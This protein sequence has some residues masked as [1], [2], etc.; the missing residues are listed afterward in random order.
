MVEVVSTFETLVN[1][2]HTTLRNYTEDCHLDTRRENVK[3]HSVC[4]WL[5]HC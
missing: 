1:F 3:Y 5:K 4:V 2:Y